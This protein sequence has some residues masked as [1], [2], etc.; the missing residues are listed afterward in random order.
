MLRAAGVAKYCNEG[1]YIELYPP[2]QVIKAPA[3]IAVPAARPDFS[4]RE[5][6][7]ERPGYGHASL[8]LVSF[9]ESKVEIHELGF[10]VP[11]PRKP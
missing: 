3:G 9:P 7:S 10:G 5:S 6:E 11:L 1:L 2:D 8:N 4:E